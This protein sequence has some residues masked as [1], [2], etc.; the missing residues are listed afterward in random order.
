MWLKR[1]DMGKVNWIKDRSVKDE[2]TKCGVYDRLR[3]TLQFL[4]KFL[5]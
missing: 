4:I 3:R 1:D 2:R 5:T